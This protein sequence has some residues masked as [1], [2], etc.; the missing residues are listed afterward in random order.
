MHCGDSRLSVVVTM[1][2][3][4]LI[5]LCGPLETDSIATCIRTLVCMFVLPSLSFLLPSFP[6]TY[7]LPSS[8]P[9]THTDGLCQQGRDAGLCSSH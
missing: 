2:R 6:S 7:L 3:K 8:S 9:I 4:D 5:D 1:K